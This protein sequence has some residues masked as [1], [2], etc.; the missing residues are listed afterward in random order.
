MP[1]EDRPG[2]DQG[3]D[4][5]E[6]LSTAMTTYGLDEQEQQLLYN[7][8]VLRVTTKRAGTI[9]GVSNP[10][11]MLQRPH[12]ISAREKMRAALRARVDIT[13]EDVVAGLKEAIDQAI[14][15]ADPMAQIAGW[16]E[17]AKMLGYDKTPNVNIHIQGTLD[18][19]RSQFR[20]MP[21]DRLLAES[22]MGGVLDADF[23]TVGKNEAA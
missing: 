6:D 19:V 16:R 22:G 18:Q 11:E 21:M 2:G 8:E 3:K 20:D 5:L 12:V 1:E 13:R 4:V 10:Y 9:A 23:V 17:I 15:L 7:V 14:I